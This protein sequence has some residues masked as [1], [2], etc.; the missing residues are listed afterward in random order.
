MCPDAGQSTT[1]TSE[2][3]EKMLNFVP[4]AKLAEVLDSDARNLILW[5]KP[6]TIALKAR[7]WAL[8]IPDQTILKR[9]PVIE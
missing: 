9:P 5:G 1:K 6:T 2:W 7:W 3:A 8:T 4:S